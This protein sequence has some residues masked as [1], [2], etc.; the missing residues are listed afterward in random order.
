M[1]FMQKINI[2][3]KIDVEDII[4]ISMKFKNGITAQLIATFVPY[5]TTQNGKQKYLARLDK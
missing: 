1:R 4:S 3:N 5:V 2:N